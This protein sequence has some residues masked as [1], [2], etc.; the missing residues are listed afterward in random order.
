MNSGYD[1]A[2]GICH[3]RDIEEMIKHRNRLIHDMLNQSQ[4]KSKS[5]ERNQS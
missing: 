5:F 2:A 3:Y 1:R 4:K